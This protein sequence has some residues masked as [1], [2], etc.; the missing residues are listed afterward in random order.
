M[1]KILVVPAKG[2]RWPSKN[3]KFAA[4]FDVRPEQ[5]ESHLGVTFERHLEDG[6]GYY[7]GIGLDLPSGRRI[8]LLWYESAPILWLRLLVDSADDLVAARGET[9]AM[10]GLTD[11]VVAWMPDA[12]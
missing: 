10:L 6:L 2:F 3:F 8:A 7:R 5:V 1:Q 4:T 12:T 11:A 9:L